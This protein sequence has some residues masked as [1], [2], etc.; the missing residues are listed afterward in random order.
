MSETSLS[1]L[2]LRT[3]RIGACLEFY[4]ALGLTLVEEKHGKGAVHD[5]SSSNGITIEIYPETRKKSAE[6][7]AE[8]TIRLGFMVESLAATLESLE[9]LGAT[10]LKPPAITQWGH[11]AVLL[12]PDGREVEINEPP[13]IKSEVTML[14]N[15]DVLTKVYNAFN[16]RDIDAVLAYMCADVDWPNGWEGGRV[17]GHEGVRD[18][19]TRQWAAIDPCVEPVGFDTDETGRAVVKVHQVV[20]NLEGNVISEGMVDHV[21]LIEDGLIKS[22]EIRKP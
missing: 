2:V 4:Q 6:N 14:T 3:T 21:Y 13:K 1:L 11:H 9:T 18:Y 16:A 8:S 17:H 22:M 10:V 19:W 7:R 15:R 20:R 5:S 12:D